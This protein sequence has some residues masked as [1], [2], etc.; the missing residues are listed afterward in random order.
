MSLSDA[1]TPNDR[2]RRTCRQRAR[3]QTTEAT[4]IN[5]VPGYNQHLVPRL[6]D[7]FW[8]RRKSIEVIAASEGL[9]RKVVQDLLR[10]HSVPIKPE[11]ATMPLAFRKRRAA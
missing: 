1:G 3:P 6:Q 9:G 2:P 8:H 5:A 10:Q 4:G 7:Q 11:P